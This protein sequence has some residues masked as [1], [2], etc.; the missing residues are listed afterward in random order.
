M[1]SEQT[2]YSRKRRLLRQHREQMRVMD[3]LIWDHDL[4]AD[5]D[6]RMVEACSTQSMSSKSKSR[7]AVPLKGA[8]GGR[9]ADASSV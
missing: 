9:D 5:L 3:D 4:Q 1:A 8:T 2:G 7:R 6:L